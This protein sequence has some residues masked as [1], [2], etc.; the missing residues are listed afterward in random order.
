[1]VGRVMYIAGFSALAFQV[2]IMA[3]D[4]WQFTH[5]FFAVGVEQDAGMATV[6][7][8]NPGFAIE[9]AHVCSP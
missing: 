4:Q 8:D 7:H 3:I 6:G 2:R 5:A 1:M 9:I